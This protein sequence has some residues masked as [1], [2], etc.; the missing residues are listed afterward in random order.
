MK[1]K[2][3]NWLKYDRNFK[4]G[5]ALYHEFGNNLALKSTFNRQ[6]E[7][8]FNQQLLQEELRKLASIDNDEFKHIISIPVR[9]YQQDAPK[10]ETTAPVQEIAS[11]EPVATKANPTDIECLK[12]NI[13]NVAKRAILL[14]D[15]FPFLREANCPRV[16]K[17]LVTDMVTAYD[18]YRKA[19]EDCFTAENEEQLLAYSK[20]TVE[21]YLEN[22]SIW[23]ELNHFK[24]TGEILGNHPIYEEMQELDEILKMNAADLAKEKKNLASAINRLKNQI[25]KGDKPDLNLSR[26]ELIESKARLLSEVETLL[27]SK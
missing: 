8:Q 27:K 26:N 11:E 25:E 10:K 24:E 12:A 6:G 15:E 17:I 3:T 2:I 4:S 21:N 9:K 1:S 5:V 18:E 23:E 19:H 20:S 7:T 13:P 22:R 14:R 16:L